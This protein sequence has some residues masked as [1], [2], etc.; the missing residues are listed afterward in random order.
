MDDSPNWITP[1][2]AGLLGILLLVLS[3]NV[4]RQ[5][6]GSKVLIGD[7]GVPALQRVVRAQANLTEYAPLALILLAG[8]E[9][10]GFSGRIVHFL[11][12]LLLVGRL[13]HGFGLT[14]SAG[15]SAPRAI[16]ASLTWLMLLLA[17]GLAI[18]GW[19]SASRF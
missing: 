2:Y 5:R 1:L 3:Y 9:V 7:G 18:F 13:L 15:P 4:S 14:R 11:G 10:Q 16:G 19:V 17:S 8:I 12:I 6:V